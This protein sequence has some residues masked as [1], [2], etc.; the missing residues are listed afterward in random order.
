M[1]T[2]RSNSA[3]RM[4]IFTGCDRYKGPSERAKMLRRILGFRAEMAWITP[5]CYA[6]FRYEGYLDALRKELVR[7]RRCN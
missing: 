4:L 5:Y 2:Y 6:W 7:V 1:T 3:Q